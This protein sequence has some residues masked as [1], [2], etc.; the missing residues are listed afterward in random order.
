M[1]TIELKSDLL[2]HSRLFLRNLDTGPL[3]KLPTGF[4]KSMVRA[5]DLKK[6]VG[7]YMR[8]IKDLIKAFHVHYLMS[9]NFISRSFAS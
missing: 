2:S 9:L 3:G 1:S 6:I 5:I 4:P 7:V 8:L